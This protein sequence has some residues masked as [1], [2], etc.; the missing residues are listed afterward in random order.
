MKK[1]I[2]LLVVA[3]VV[4]ACGKKAAPQNAG[5]M[6]KADP[7]DPCAGKAADPCA[8]KAADPCAGK[9]ADPCAGKKP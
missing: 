7:A 5:D 3:F 1:L 2:L 8:G 6:K 4:P 9:A